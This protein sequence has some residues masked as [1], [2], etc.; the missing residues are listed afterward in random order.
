M[1][2]TLTCIKTFESGVN[3]EYESDVDIFKIYIWELYICTVAYIRHINDCEG[4]N[5]L[6]YYTYFLKDSIFGG[7]AKI[8]NYTRFR[9]H[10]RMIKEDIS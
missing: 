9:F 6:L 10:S 2:N 4:L 3:S 1:Y 7:T 8:N 5:V